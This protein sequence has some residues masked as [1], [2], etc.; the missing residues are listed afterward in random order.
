MLLTENRAAL[1]AIH[2]TKQDLQDPDSTVLYAAKELRFYLGRMTAAPFAIEASEDASACAGSASPAGALCPGIFLGAASTLPVSD[3]G[4]DGYAIEATGTALRI[5]GGNRGIIYG[6]YEFLEQMGCRFFTSTVEKIPTCDTLE[7]GLLSIRK[8]PVLEYREHNYFDVTTHPRFAVKCRLNGHFHPIPA[9]MG[10]H[11]S[12]AYFVHSFANLIPLE[13]FGETHPEFFALVDGERVRLSGGRYQLCLTNPEL[14]DIAIDRTRKALLAHPGC[15]IISLSQNDWDIHCQCENCVKVDRE[16][17]SPAANLIRFVNAVAEALEP[18]FPN[19]I[20][21]TLAYQHTRQAPRFTRNRHNVCVRLCSIEACFAHPFET[22]DDETRMLT[23][24]DGSKTRFI[25]DLREWGQICD[26][27]Y[28][29][30]YTTCFRHYP[31]PHPNWRCLQKNLQAMVK[32][33]VRGVFE[34][35]NG[36]SRGGVDFNELRLYLI[37]K[38]LWDPD[39]DLEKHRREFLEYYYGPAADDLDAYLNRLCDVVEE[40]NIHVGFNDDPIA[41]F[42]REELLDEYEAFFDRAAAKVQNDPLRLWRVE[43]N[44]LSIRWVRLKRK[45]MLRNE[46]DAAEIEKFFADWRAFGLSG[47]N[48]WCNIETTHRA[49]LEQKWCGTEF[50]EHWNMEEEELF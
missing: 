23:R 35:A 34:Q 18:E 21:D 17:G 50:W 6:V 24:P 16:E 31:T 19:V 10:G 5:N 20:F 12:Y 15:R 30:D 14:L 2:I 8:R 46:F 36:A 43:K 45:T 32:N 47:I 26:R 22:C 4:E 38:M 41:P 13:E 48:E 40:E 42:L 33:N 27:M 9:R 11:L 44:R 29:W 37:T 25:D 39:C 7:T 3:L 28:I 1:S 49:M